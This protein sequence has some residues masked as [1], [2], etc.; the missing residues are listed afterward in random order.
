MSFALF[1]FV[2]SC[3]KEI[4]GGEEIDPARKKEMLNY[5]NGPKVEI[6]NLAQFQKKANLSALG[7][8]KQEFMTA[9]S[10]KSKKM[11]IHTDQTYL[12]FSIATD[13]IKV[14][15]A[16][17]HTMY[18]FPVELPSKRAV[19]FQNLTIDEGPDGTI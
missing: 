11:S 1:L 3:K 9:L 14:I 4:S 17:G 10:S 15:K 6:I 8:L 2:Y 12:G 16:N 5:K 18:V 19:A 13:S 7:N